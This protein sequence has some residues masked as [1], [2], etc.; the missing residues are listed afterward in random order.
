MITSYWVWVML[1]KIKSF[2]NDESGATALEYAF[3]AGIVSL[4][5]VG[6]SGSIGESFENIVVTVSNTVTNATP[7]G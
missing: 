3:I 7:Q 6:A 1:N 4:V 2:L 5:V